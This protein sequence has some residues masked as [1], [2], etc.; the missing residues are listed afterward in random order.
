MEAPAAEAPNNANTTKANNGNNR[1]RRR[2]MIVL[3]III[4]IVAVG[5]GLYWWLVARFREST[6]DAYVAGNLVQIT[7]QTTGT[8]N[9]IRADDTDLV[10][11]GETLITLDQTDAKLALAR[12]EADLAQSVRQIRNLFVTTG[13]F[14]AT[15]RLRQVELQRAEADVKRRAAVVGAGGVSGEELQHARDAVTAAR[16]AIT[17]ATEQLKGNQSLIEGT[18]VAE[19]PAVRAAAARVRDAF[20]TLRR[21]S[22][23]S[24]VRGYVAKRSGQVGARVS[25]GMPLMAIVPLDDLWVEANF[26]EVQLR[27]LRLNQP[28]TLVADL[29]GDKVEYQGKVIGLG[30][31]TGSAFAL[32]PAQNATGNWI[33][34]VQRVPVRV[35]LNP[36]Q[37][38]QHPLRVGLSMEVTADIHNLDGPV[39]AQAPRTTS[40]YSTSV[41]DKDMRETDERIAAI[42]AANSGDGAAGE[43][44]NGSADHSGEG[45]VNHQPSLRETE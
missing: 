1:K 34:V 15:V 31:G 26:K 14:E 23:V 28:V 4:L 41:Y 25:P 17:V 9:S 3:A 11:P 35:G 44:V 42:I 7:P 45:A 20:L 12:A 30:V 10:R 40:A 39:L 8:I 16:A 43:R 18:T 24:P 22:I 5:Y 13:Q 6:D 27:H 33:K 38:A 29:Y 36:R 21:S 19:H 2:V 37:L 32:L